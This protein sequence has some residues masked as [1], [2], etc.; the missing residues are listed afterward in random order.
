LFKILASVQ[1]LKIWTLSKI[2]CSLI[3]TLKNCYHIQIQR[4]IILFYFIL[5]KIIL[6]NV[7]HYWILRLFNNGS[8]KLDKWQKWYIDRQTRFIRHTH[9]FGL[10]KLFPG[11][12]CFWTVTTAEMQ[13]E[14]LN[15]KQQILLHKHTERKTS[16]KVSL[17]SNGSEPW[18][19]KVLN[20]G[21]INIERYKFH[22]T[23]LKASVQ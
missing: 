20:G 18:T 8:V 2:D 5:I 12:C 6:W 21:H 22:I 10:I 9:N 19:E 1:Q 7:W 23:E 13:T 14:S 15:E 11:D 3:Y 17:T 16:M 4:C